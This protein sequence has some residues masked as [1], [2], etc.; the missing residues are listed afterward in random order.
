MQL[1]RVDNQQLVLD[2]N[3]LARVRE[4][5]TNTKWVAVF[6]EGRSGKSFL[7][8]VLASMLPYLFILFYFIFTFYQYLVNVTFW[9]KLNY[10]SLTIIIVLPFYEI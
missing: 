10:T 6:G 9:A 8:N 4:F 7:S 2:P 5:P 3:T 1:A